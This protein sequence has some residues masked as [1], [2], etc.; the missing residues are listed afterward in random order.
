MS[1]ELVR[2]PSQFPRPWECPFPQ[3]LG[4]TL[5]EAL[6][7]QEGSEPTPLWV[8]KEQVWP[9]GLHRA[10]EHLKQQVQNPEAGATVTPRQGHR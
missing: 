7:C 1:I 9:E 2:W 3:T 5:Q 4:T 10:W 6:Q 8:G